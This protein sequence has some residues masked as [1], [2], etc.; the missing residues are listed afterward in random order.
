MK[1]LKRITL[2]TFLALTSLTY[3][4]FENEELESLVGTQ[5][6]V[7]INLGAMMLGL[8]SSATENEEQ[9]IANILSS[10]DSIKVKVYELEK[11]NK[12]VD[13]STLKNIKL[14]INQ[15]AQKQKKQGYEVLAKVKEDDSLVYVLAKMDKK[16]FKSLSILALDDDD[17]LVLI[18]IEG[19]ILMSQLGDLM[20][21]FNVDLDI[22]GLKIQKQAKKDQ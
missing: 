5:P 22:N 2:F 18:N 19:T 10:L 14:K 20:E 12:T 15:L 21:H 16:N 7:E 6:S 3:A 13:K 8:L 11:T 1:T 17:E 4:Q 9:G